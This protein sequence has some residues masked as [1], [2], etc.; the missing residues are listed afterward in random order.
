MHNTTSNKGAPLNG[1]P[2]TPQA[3]YNSFN[4]LSIALW[5]TA[6][7]VEEARQA[8]AASGHM[9]RQAGCCV[10]LSIFRTIGGRI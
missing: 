5:R 3:H 1:T 4:K 7:A 10:A 2:S 9:W 6:Y 8:H